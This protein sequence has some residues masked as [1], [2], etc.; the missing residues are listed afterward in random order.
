MKLIV[1]STLS[2]MLQVEMKIN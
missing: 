1:T 2:M